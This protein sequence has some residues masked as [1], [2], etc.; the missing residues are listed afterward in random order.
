M[1]NIDALE[2]SMLRGR[3]EQLDEKIEGVR[4]EVRSGFAGMVYIYILH[5][6]PVSLIPHKTEIQST[7]SK[8]T[9][10]GTIREILINVHL[11]RVCT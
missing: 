3:I 1:A 11:E 10:L 8:Y 6:P 9:P 5:R 2:H 4:I 7:L